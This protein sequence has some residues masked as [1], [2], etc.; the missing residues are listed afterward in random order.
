MGINGSPVRTM[1]EIGQCASANRRVD[2]IVGLTDDNL[3]ELGTWVELL[4][5]VALR[6]DDD[7]YNQF[8]T[9]VRTVAEQIR[10]RP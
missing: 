10:E 4:P 6:T 3:K 9:D 8:A 7:E 2:V 5:T 1:F